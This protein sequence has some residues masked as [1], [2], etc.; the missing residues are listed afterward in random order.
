MKKAINGW[1]TSVA[2]CMMNVFDDE[3]KC[4]NI[5]AC[6]SNVHNIIYLH[7]IK[8]YDLCVKFLFVM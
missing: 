1:M 3:K 2:G 4:K 7:V 6:L 5:M 8:K